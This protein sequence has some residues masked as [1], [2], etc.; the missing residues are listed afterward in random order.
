MLLPFFLFEDQF[1]QI[2][3]RLSQGH[4]TAAASVVVIVVLLALDVVLPVPSSLISAGAGAILGFWLATTVVWIGMT[5]GCVV[6]YVVG[7]SGAGAA[8]RFV[9]HNHLD[10]AAAL[11]RRH[12]LWAL[13][14]CRP[15]PVAAEASVVFAG[16]MRT[17]MASVLAM[18]ALS[19][20]GIAAAYAAVG[21]YAMQVNSFGLVFGGAI[22]LP[23]VVL[24][25]TRGFVDRQ[26]PL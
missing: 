17:P 5:V 23:A 14:V 12:G 4:L 1:T 8:R 15:I 6:A 18:T 16:L 20:V 13:V 2:G 10:R 24:L 9:G 25:V 3:A 19:N 26:R 7:A 22:S 11:A 21:A